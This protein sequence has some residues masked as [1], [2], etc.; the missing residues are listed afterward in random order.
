MLLAA[1]FIWAGSVSAVLF[2]VLWL[3]SQPQ[4]K[5]GQVTGATPFVSFQGQPFQH[6]KMDTPSEVFK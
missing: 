6:Q 4:S 3:D 5:L 2:S 1:F